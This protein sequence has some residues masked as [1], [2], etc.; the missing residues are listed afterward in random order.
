MN[1]ER[2]GT[3]FIKLAKIMERLRSKENGCPWDAVQTSETIIV[4]LIEE[5]YEVIEAIIDKK[6][7][8]LG[9]ELG[10]LLMQ[11]LF[12]ARIAEEEGYFD[13]ETV[14]D[15]ITNKLVVRHPHVFGNTEVN[16]VE[17][18]LV[19]WENIKETKEKKRDSRLSGVPKRMPALARAFRIQEKVA[20]F[21]FDWR[22]KEGAF[23]KIEEEIA[24]L[25]D[26]MAKGSKEDKELEFGDLLF[27]LVNFARHTGIEPELALTKSINKFINRFKFV[28]QAIKQDNKDMSDMDIAHL[29]EYW[30]RAKEEI[31]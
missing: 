31:E 23:E 11:I 17:D 24:E 12:H 22:D 9:E 15:G 26:E 4:N 5:S 21:G 13:L 19:N 20:R 1:Y 7:D 3:K 29:D 6:Y 16:T 25:K 8:D 30:D 18:V 28:E 14:I 2:L 10:D 27:S